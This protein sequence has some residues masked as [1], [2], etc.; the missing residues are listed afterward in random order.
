MDLTPDEK[1]ICEYLK[2]R[3]GHYVSA[4]EICREAGGKRKSDEDWAMSLLRDMMG[5]HLLETDSRGN[6]RLKSETEDTKSKTK[7]RWIAPH[8]QRIL[9]QSGKNFEGID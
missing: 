2:S 8:I 7:K 9:K 6:Y 4:K 1:A 5:K 3:S